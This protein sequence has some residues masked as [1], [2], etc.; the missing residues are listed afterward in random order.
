M[1][2]QGPADTPAAGG[3]N[4]PAQTSSTFEPST[5]VSGAQQNDRMEQDKKAEMALQESATSAQ[6]PRH[7]DNYAQ[8]FASDLQSVFATPQASLLRDYYEAQRRSNLSFHQQIRDILERLETL[9]ES[10]AG[11]STES[12]SNEA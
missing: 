9:G 7:D 1:S 12:S 3:Q 11:A 8:Q 4:P 2:S 10:L 6:Q 5:D